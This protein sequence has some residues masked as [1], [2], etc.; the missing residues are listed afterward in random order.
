M[1]SQRD[2][3]FLFEVGSLNNLQRSWRQHLGMDCAGVLGH[4]VRVIW[5]AL[6][7]ARMEGVKNDEA[8]I[9]MALVH[10]LPETRTSDIGYVQKAYIK[11]DEQLAA[12][13]IFIDTS[14]EPIR[15]E[16]LEV[17]RRRDSIEAK[18]VK[19]ADNLDVDIELR[20]LAARGFQTPSRWLDDRQKVRDLKLYTV[21]AKK[22]WD[23][24]KDADPQSWFYSANKWT[25]NLSEE[26]K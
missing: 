14:V 15:E 1:S 6:I 13:E 24:I 5:L 22:M 18:I 2:L 19:D 12:K 16:S 26:S 21:S 7:L 17:Y 8:I 3:E 11:S 9:K 10:D 23:E 4:T 20:E 25:R